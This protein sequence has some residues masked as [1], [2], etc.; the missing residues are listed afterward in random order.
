MKVGEKK[1]KKSRILPFS[2]LPIGTN[3]QNLAIWVWICIFL[4]F[5]IWRIWVIFF[6]MVNPL[7]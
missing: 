6:S 3:F 1:K 4:I 2:W 5:K 7:Y